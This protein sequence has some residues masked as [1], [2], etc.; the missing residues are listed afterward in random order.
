MSNKRTIQN[1]R[2]SQNKTITNLFQKTI[3]SVVVLPVA[4]KN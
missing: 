4:V 1:K 2:N 3:M